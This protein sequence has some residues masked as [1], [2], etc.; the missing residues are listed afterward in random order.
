MTFASFKASFRSDIWGAFFRS[1]KPWLPLTSLRCRSRTTPANAP[2]AL[3][4]LFLASSLAASNSE[5]K[6]SAWAS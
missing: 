5:S 6:R 2:A 1:V 4:N 3:V